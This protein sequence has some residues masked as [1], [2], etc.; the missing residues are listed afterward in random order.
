MIFNITLKDS[1][2]RI[3]LLLIKIY[4]SGFPITHQNG[5]ASLGGFEQS[6]FR[7]TAER[8]NRLRNRDCFRITAKFSKY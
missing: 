3:Q 6:T 1:C 2:V 5:K 8:V 4:S 7:L